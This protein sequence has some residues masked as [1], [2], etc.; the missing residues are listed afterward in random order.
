MR[1]LY[2]HEL[3]VA[4]LCY[5]RTLENQ[6]SYESL[7]NRPHYWW[8]RLKAICVWQ[9]AH[10]T[11]PLSDGAQVVTEPKAKAEMLNVAFASQ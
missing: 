5:Y 10:S 9:T 7:K 11:S 3:R 6:L 8:S 1:N 4:E 2:V